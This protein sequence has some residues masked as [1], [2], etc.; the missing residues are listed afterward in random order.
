MQM[1]SATLFSGD[2][3]HT[4]QQK[5]SLWQ[6][7]YQE[8]IQQG[9]FTL[10]YP[11]VEAELPPEA[12]GKWRNAYYRELTANLR[13]DYEHTELHSL[14]TEA[15]IPYVS[16]K[17]VA[18]ASYYPEPGLRMMGDVD[19]LIRREDVARASRLLESLGFERE[20]GQ[21]DRSDGI[22]I[23]Y[24]RPAADGTTASIWE[25]HWSVNGI[26]GGEAGA[27]VRGYLDGLIENAKDC[28]TAGG[29]VKVP[30]AFCHGLILLLHTASHMTY[31]GVGLRHLCD[32][33]VFADHFSESEFTTLFED[34]LKKAGLWRFAQLLTL[35]GVQFLGCP[36][37]AWAGNAPETLL[38]AMIRDI[39]DG[40]NFGKKDADRYRQIKY[41]ANWD[42]RT[43]DDRSVLRQALSTIH[44]KART[45]YAFVKKFPILLPL[46]WICIVLQYVRR[47][48]LKERQM[49]RKETLERAAARKRI[50]RE[51]HLFEK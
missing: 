30:D 48:V 25:L 20:D 50:Y 4:E 2:W 6:E 40:G 43:V 29:T 17:G 8:S 7:I 22:H 3:E 19:F 18:S 44:Y 41:I 32:W 11:V 23:G 5:E 42:G 36:P 51:F 9:V 10:I 12:Q 1:V 21:P 31:E 26:P 27:T 15:G 39:C 45:E 28:G 16:L 46:G 33:L 34:K 13:V 14:L 49:D 37:K 35:C 47:V 38:E 24:H